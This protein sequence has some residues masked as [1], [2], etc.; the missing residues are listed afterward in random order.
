MVLDQFIVAQNMSVSHTTAIL[1][2]TFLHCVT[3]EQDS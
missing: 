1:F 2:S 3:V